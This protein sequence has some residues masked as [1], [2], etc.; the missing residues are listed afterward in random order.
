MVL[1]LVVVAQTLVDKMVHKKAV[2][3]Y[4]DE[5]SFF[6]CLKECDFFFFFF[7][8]LIQNQINQFFYLLFVNI[9]K[10]STWKLWRAFLQIICQCV[11]MIRM[12][13]RN[14]RFG[15]LPHVFAKQ[16]NRTVLSDDML[17]VCSIFIF[18]FQLFQFSEK[19]KKET[20]K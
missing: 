8:I 19:K 5:D 4:L 20:K 1:P 2:L 12:S 6:V 11:S 13:N 7:S 18:Q 15:T 3:L 17:H 16:I 14:Q 9:Q 10:H